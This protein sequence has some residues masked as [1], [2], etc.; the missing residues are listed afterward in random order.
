MG[1]KDSITITS[2]TRSPTNKFHLNHGKTNSMSY[3]VT[4]F[5]REIVCDKHTNI[6]K[7]ILI[8]RNE[9]DEE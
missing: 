8:T 7:K 5:K 1:R 2:A 6:K 3:E 4:N 9:E